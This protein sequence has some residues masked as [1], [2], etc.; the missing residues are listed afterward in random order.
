MEKV[1]AYKI[2]RVLQPDG[3]ILC[4]DYHVNNPNNPDVK[5]VKKEEIYERFPHV[6]FI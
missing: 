6:K 3:I 1:I 5:G 4:Y 2:S